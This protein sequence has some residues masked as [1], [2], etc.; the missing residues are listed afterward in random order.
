MGQPKPGKYIGVMSGTSM[1]G[2]DVVLAEIGET[3]VTQ[4]A[5]HSYVIPDDLKDR[6]LSMIAGNAITLTDVVE[7][8]ARLGE[9]FS[10]AINTFLN[11]QGI[12]AKDI[13]AIGCHGQTVWHSPQGQFPSTLQLGDNN[14]IVAATGI[15]TVGDF[16][17]RD[18][19][20]GGQGAPL[21]PAFHQMLLS[22]PLERRIV[23]NIGGMANISVLYPGLPVTGFDTGPGNVLLDGWIR[24]NTGKPY[25]K[26]ALWA[27][28]GNRDAKL[29]QKMLSDP[30]FAKIAP[31]ST[32][33]EYFNLD[34]LAQFLEQD[35]TIKAEDV[36][37]TLVEL[38][39]VTIADQV[40]QL[41]GCLR[42]LVCGGGAHNP[43]LM[44]R[45]ADLLPTVQV[46][47]TDQYGISGDDM[48]ALA[49][50]WL[51]YRTLSGLPGN[52]PS[53]TGARQESILGAIFPA[54][55]MS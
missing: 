45:L 5:A 18:M 35:H 41:G 27:Q 6:L 36:Q 32:G 15:T 31:K 44:A 17:R 54:D 43:L 46:C 37:A 48:E 24:K 9:L 3:T 4:L 49:F 10:E 34:W 38:T 39:A 7:F 26:D 30:Y 8:D 16:R 51:A 20:L 22:H 21:V 55:R 28:K 52:L 1:D 19:A 33:R 50:A 25:D 29:L 53:V 42:L 12:D 47:A 13:M 11:V 14:R 40:K 2:I 23:L